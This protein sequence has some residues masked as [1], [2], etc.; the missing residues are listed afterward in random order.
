MARYPENRFEDLRGP[1]NL[2]RAIEGNEAEGLLTATGINPKS[3]G[4]SRIRSMAPED[5][6]E[7]HMGRPKQ[8][9]LWKVYDPR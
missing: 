5:Q 2:S 7:L 6:P 9:S 8:S 4:G 1:T 3:I